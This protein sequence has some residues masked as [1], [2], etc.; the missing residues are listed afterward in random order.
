[1]S[2]KWVC[3]S[4]AVVIS[5]AFAWMINDI[6]VHTRQTLEK[7]K[8]S[9]EIAADVSQD[10]KA[11]RKLAGIGGAAGDTRLTDYANE[12]MDLIDSAP[13][14]NIG[15][16]KNG[17]NKL[18][19]P[20]PLK[21]WSRGARKEAVLLVLRAKSEADILR[22]LCRSKWGSNFGIQVGNEPPVTLEQWLKDRHAPSKDLKL[23]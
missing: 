22:G 14:A 2:F 8:V 13:T 3:F 18:K 6:R 17:D 1:M 19:D 7:V 4:V 12:V 10:V 5:L 21:E 11:L 20:V 15:V 9:A 16:L 23:D